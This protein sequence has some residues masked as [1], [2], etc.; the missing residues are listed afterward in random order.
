MPKMQVILVAASR[1]ELAGALLVAS[2]NVKK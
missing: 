1:I 2:E